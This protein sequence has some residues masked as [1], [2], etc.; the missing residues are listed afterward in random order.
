VAAKLI[1]RIHP[2]DVHVGIRL[3]QRRLQVGLS[4]EGLGAKVGVRAQQIQKYEKGRDRIAASRLYL[5]AASLGIPVAYFFVGLS[6]ADRKKRKR[7][8]GCRTGIA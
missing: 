5:L 1:T 8:S 6:S 3:R 2:I 4:L 7:A